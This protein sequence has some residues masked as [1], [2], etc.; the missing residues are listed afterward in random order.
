MT[1]TLRRGVPQ[2]TFGDRLRKARRSAGL[3]VREFARSLDVGVSSISQYETDR[4]QPRDLAAFARRVELV[5][6]A[7]AAW[8]T[9]E[10]DVQVKRL[11]RAG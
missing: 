4:Q 6:G 10:D 8:L 5:T 1:T 11:L 9:G 7:P 3:T 2:W